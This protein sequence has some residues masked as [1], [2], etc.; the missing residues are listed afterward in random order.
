M[1]GR[2]GLLY[3][4]FLRVVKCLSTRSF[5]LTLPLLTWSSF[6]GK[7][8]IVRSWVSKVKVKI[9]MYV[10][11][12]YMVCMVKK[13]KEKEKKEVP[14]FILKERK[15]ITPYFSNKM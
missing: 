6:V 7:M 8:Y 12:M 14:E 13:R 3:Q 15:I 10:L 2:Y 1:I 4:D 9:K 5:I 11:H